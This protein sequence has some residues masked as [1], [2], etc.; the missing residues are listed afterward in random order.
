MYLP[1]T[2][3][4]NEISPMNITINTGNDECG[5][6]YE[7][8]MQHMDDGIFLHTSYKVMSFPASSLLLV[9]FVMQNVLLFYLNRLSMCYV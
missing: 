4:S 5:I 7:N 2:A 3:L 8:N 1:I 6:S 9:L